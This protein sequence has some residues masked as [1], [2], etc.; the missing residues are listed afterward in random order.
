MSDR[1][2]PTTGEQIA[3]NLRDGRLS[4]WAAPVTDAPGWQITTRSRCLAVAVATTLSGG[5]V[6]SH[7]K[8]NGRHA[9]PKR[10]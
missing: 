2:P 7:E 1:L 5:T 6:H 10:S 4:P 3:R 8:A 9:C